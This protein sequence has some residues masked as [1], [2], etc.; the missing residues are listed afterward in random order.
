MAGNTSP[1]SSRVGDIQYLTSGLTA[2]TALDGTGTVAT[3]FIA[4]ATN[5][6]RA[7]RVRLLHLGTNITTVA[8]F[9][10]NNGSTNATAANNALF[11]E[12][13]MAANTLSQV[14]ASVAQ[15]IA[16][17]MALPPGYKINMTIGT[18]IAAGIMGTVIGGK[19]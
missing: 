3:L 1:I 6:G 17:A 15:E 9:F 14:A 2:N 8:R 12:T 4:D 7:E 5:G 18:A 11:L 19:Y 10:I 13:T 16:L